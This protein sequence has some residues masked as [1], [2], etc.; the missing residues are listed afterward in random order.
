LSA[1]NWNN[2]NGAGI[3]SFDVNGVT[4]RHN[5]NYLTPANFD[6]AV[7]KTPDKNDNPAIFTVI[8]RTVT[9]TNMRKSM[10]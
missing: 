9:N 2:G 5:R 3:N 10:K 6:S 4:L 8:E 1:L 7:A